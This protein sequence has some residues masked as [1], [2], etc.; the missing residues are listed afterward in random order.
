FVWS[1]ENHVE[2]VLSKQGCNMGICHGAASG[3]GGF[4]LTLRAY[5]PDLD[6]AR[7]RYEGRGRRIVKTDPVSSLLLKK[8]SLAVAHM[9][10]LHLR[11][12]WLEYGVLS[13]W[14]AAGTPGPR[15]NGPKIVGL[16]VA[17][18]ERTLT[19]GT[20]QRLL[21]TARFSDGHAEDV[22]HWARY[23]ASEET[24]AKVD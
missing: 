11:G 15:P 19:P 18:R 16:E 4:R 17:P 6:Y 8:P 12:E 5:D 10:G 2:S 3:K 22:T 13:E 23:T 7:L 9:R 1:F 24:L 14:I 21:V 20:Q